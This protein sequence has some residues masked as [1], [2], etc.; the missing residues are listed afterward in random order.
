MKGN[1]QSL[2][3]WGL[4]I[5]K[6]GLMNVLFATGTAAT[7]LA[8]PVLGD[9]PVNGGPDWANEAGADGRVRSF[10]PLGGEDDLFALA[11]TLPSEPR[12][13]TVASL[14]D[15]NGRKLRRPLARGR[16]LVSATLCTPSSLQRAI[17]PL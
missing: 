7:S 11:T 6:T 9:R 2:S 12:P 5:A 16:E 14:V 15:A 17:P 13:D 10:A 4:G 8:P 3:V 1:C